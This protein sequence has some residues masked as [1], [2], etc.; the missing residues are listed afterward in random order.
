MRLENKL[1]IVDKTCISRI[2]RQTGDHRFLELNG[3]IDG[4]Y[5]GYLP[6]YEQHNYINLLYG[7]WWLPLPQY[8]FNDHSKGCINLNYIRYINL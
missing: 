6:V 1:I 5:H 2:E 3:L 8:K 4:N 7:G